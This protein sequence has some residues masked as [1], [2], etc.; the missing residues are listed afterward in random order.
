MSNLPA[1]PGTQ[2][3]GIVNQQQ[4][5]QQGAQQGHGQQG[6]GFGGLPAAFQPNMQQQQQG[7][8][9]QQGQGVVQGGQSAIP[10]YVTHC[11]PSYFS[12]TVGMFPSSQSLAQRARL[13]LGLIVHPMAAVVAGGAP[14]LPMVDFGQAGIVRC[15]PCRA[16]INPFVTFLDGGNRWKCNLCGQHNDVPAKYFAQLDTNG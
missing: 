14:A 6:G 3:G 15:K 1:G 13:P 8:Q 11:H 2:A 16:Y 5:A 9:W 4:G 10:E 7:Q 12:T